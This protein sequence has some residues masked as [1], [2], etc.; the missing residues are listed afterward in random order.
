[1]VA[2]A[3]RTASF[4]PA[5]IF[6]PVPDT[7]SATET[8]AARRRAEDVR[9][10]IT[11]V[12]SFE[13]AMDEVGGSELGTLSQGDL[14]PALE[15]ALLGLSP[16]EVS[17]AIRGP[18]GFHIFLLRSRERA[19]ANLP[20]YDDVRMQIYRQMVESA[21]S[22]QERIFLSELRRRAIIDVRLEGHSSNQQPIEEPAEE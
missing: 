12:D 8:A 19:S 2:R 10:G 7:A 6:I 9:E 18:A 20:A 13:E 3:R 16:G 4:V 14:A 17:P 22:R 21:M 1:M 11:D 5:H 15:E